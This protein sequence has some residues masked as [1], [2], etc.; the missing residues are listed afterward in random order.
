[1][2]KDE[3]GGPFVKALAS[4]FLRLSVA[5]K[6]REELA[7]IWDGRGWQRPEDG[8]RRVFRGQEGAQD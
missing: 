2:L 3:F 5:I 4:E 1:M 6:S 8:W 7:M